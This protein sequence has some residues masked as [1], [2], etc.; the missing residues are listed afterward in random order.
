MKLDNLLKNP[1]SNILILGSGYI[2][3]HLFNHL[4]HRYNVLIAD[5]KTLDYHDS[6]VLTKYMLSNEVNLVINCSGFTGRPNVD[7]AEH[8]KEECWK[9]N[10][11]SPL[12][13]N[14]TCRRLL[15]RYLHISSGCIYSGYDKVFNEK[16][17]P[18][19]GLYDHSSFYSKS[20]HAFETVSR[21]LDNKILR[22]RMPICN[23]LTNP[24]NYLKKIMDYPNLVNYI[25]SKT[26]IPELCMFVEA[27]IDI[28]EPWI[29]QDIY[30]VVN[31]S[32]FDT[33]EVVGHLNR[34]NEGNWKPL[35]PKWV[36]IEDLDIVA[37]R[38]N[39]VLS[40]KKADTIFKMSPEHI[41]M[42]M[43]CNYNNGI[44]AV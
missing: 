13:V 33:K 19:F 2:G 29:G 37:P 42:N 8:R 36:E 40:T 43:V 6:K 24:R 22:I 21:H 9:L 25:N 20:K 23:D 3:N 4:K 1:W 10:V 7:E 41:M 26:Y 14:H 35:E 17:T 32:P 28:K 30:N 31:P 34:M 11:S 15:S 27:L 44:A 5:S 12:M 39:C 16:D 18:N 38:S